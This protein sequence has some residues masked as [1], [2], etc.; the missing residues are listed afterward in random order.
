MKERA[1]KKAKSMGIR[2]GNFWK[3]PPVA[4]W[5]GKIYSAEFKRGRHL[6]FM[7]ESEDVWKGVRITSIQA[8]AVIPA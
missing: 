7:R 4:P 1:L 5:P 2:S 8:K 6:D 3:K